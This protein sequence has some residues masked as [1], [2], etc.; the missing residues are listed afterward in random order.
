MRADDVARDGQAEA[1]AARR[2][3]LE[4]AEGALAPA[5]EAALGQPVVVVNTKSDPAGEVS[6]WLGGGPVVRSGTAS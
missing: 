6:E 2:A 3:A 4:G 5:L 1:G